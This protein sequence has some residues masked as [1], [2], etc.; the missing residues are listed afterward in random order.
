M[1][2]YL[3]S[4]PYLTTSYSHPNPSTLMTCFLIRKGC[5]SH[6][7]TTLPTNAQRRKNPWAY[8]CLS[9]APPQLQADFQKRGIN[10]K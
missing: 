6:Q 9:E 2:H 10:P 5:L 1:K 8:T 3:H 7:A 4:L